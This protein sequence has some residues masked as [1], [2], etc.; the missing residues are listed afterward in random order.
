MQLHLLYQRFTLI[1]CKF[2]SVALLIAVIFAF[3]LSQNASCYKIYW[4]FISAEEYAE[5][6]QQSFVDLK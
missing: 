3:Q 6:I 4:N 2:Q 5:C 1:L